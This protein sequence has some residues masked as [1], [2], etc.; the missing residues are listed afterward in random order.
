MKPRK[1]E[2]T[3]GPLVRWAGWIKVGILTRLSKVEA[4][5]LAVLAAHDGHNGSFPSI[6]TIGRLT[7]HKA[8]RL[9]V[10]IKKLVALRIIEPHSKVRYASGRGLPI[11]VYTVRKPPQAGE[12]MSHGKPPSDGEV[13]GSKTSPAEDG[14]PP[15]Q[16]HE[17]LPA[18]GR[19]SVLVRSVKEVGAAALR[20]ATLEDASLRAAEPGNRSAGGEPMDPEL[21]AAMERAR[22]SVLR[23][24][25]DTPAAPRPPSTLLPIVGILDPLLRDAAERAGQAVARKKQKDAP[26]P[27]ANG[28]GH[29][30]PAV[31][32]HAMAESSTR[33]D[34]CPW[35]TS[36][37]EARP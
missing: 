5:V 17:N 3:S 12:V 1:G 7:G 4:D 34:E 23:K 32:A 14:K 30:A 37:R 20:S 18:R 15:Q 29:D 10:V 25:D 6:P 9:Y 11:N 31:P 28:S 21:E 22:Q 2:W 19:Q 36:E 8:N 26:P 27:D 24:R 35:E 16:R 13:I 33:A